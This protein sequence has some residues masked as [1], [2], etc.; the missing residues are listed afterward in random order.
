MTTTIMKSIQ[1]PLPATTLTVKQCSSI[2]APLL[3]QGL[4]GIGVVRTLPRVIVYGPVRLQGL[5]I[6]CLFTYQMVDHIQRVLKF[7]QA[8]E[9]LTGQLLRQSLEATKLEISCEGP[10]LTKSYEVFKWLVTPTWLTHL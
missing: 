2:M 10:M 7:C 9:H 3:A 8:K 6:P 1:Y 4:S 5:G